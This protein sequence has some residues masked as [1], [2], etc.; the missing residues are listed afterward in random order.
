MAEAQVAGLFLEFR[1]VLNND[2]GGDLAD[3]GS[4]G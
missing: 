2:R 3:Y 1:F 4:K